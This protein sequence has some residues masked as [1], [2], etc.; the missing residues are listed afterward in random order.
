MLIFLLTSFCEKEIICSVPH[1]VFVDYAFSSETAIVGDAGSKFVYQN[2]AAISFYNSRVSS[3][4][5]VALSFSRDTGKPPG[6]EF[7]LTG[8]F[9]FQIMI[10]LFNNKSTV[11]LGIWVGEK[12]AS[13]I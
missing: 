8:T 11:L 7:F 10:L 9:R 13:L 4:A 3:S 6:M 2:G 5:A 1:F 12:L